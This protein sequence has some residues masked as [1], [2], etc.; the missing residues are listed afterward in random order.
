MLM[1]GLTYLVPLLVWPYLMR[2]L[3]AEKFGYIGFALAVNQYLMIAVDFGFNLSATKRIAVSEGDQEAI[4]RIFSHTLWAKLLLMFISFVVLCCLAA[5]PRYAVYRP[6]LFL[7]FSMVV[8][9]VFTFVWLFQGRGKIRVVT[10]VNSLTKLALLP[11]T[12]FLVQSPEHYLR[13]AAL[14]AAVYIVAALITD[15]MAWKMKL[16][17]YVRVK[18]DGVKEALRDSFPLFLSQAASSVYAMLFVVILGYV[19]SPDEVGRYAA[20]EKLMRMSC[21][22][23]FTPMVQAF[24][25]RVSQLAQANSVDVHATIRRLLYAGGVMM[26]A[27][28]IVL[29]WFADPIVTLLGQ[30]YVGMENLSRIMAIVPLF[31]TLGGIMGQMGLLAAGGKQDKKVYRNIYLL[32]ALCSIILVAMLVPTWKSVGAATALLLTEGLVCVAMWLSY[33]KMRKR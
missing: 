21:V 11:L 32:A 23:I 20:A 7:L 8:G 14:Q 13:A 18:W 24:F 29:F 16:A 19:A 15:V 12:F 9:Q 30:D 10:I 33:R 25:P 31:V 27:V 22:L 4:D 3:G 28:F 1:Q 26:F 5:V 2:V 17:R 6:A